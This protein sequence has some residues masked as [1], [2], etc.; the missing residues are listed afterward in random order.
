MNKSWGNSL[1]LTCFIR[2][3]ERSSRWNEKTL[4]SNMKMYKNIK[5]T[6][7]DNYIVKNTLIFYY[8]GM[9]II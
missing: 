6:G 1:P 8:G 3:A 4:T 5:Y 9:S 7:K 2:N